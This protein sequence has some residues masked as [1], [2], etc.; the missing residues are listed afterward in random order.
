MRERVPV[1][2][3]P[4][5]YEAGNAVFMDIPDSSGERQYQQTSV[6]EA[7]ELADLC[8]RRADMQHLELFEEAVKQV[9]ARPCRN[10]CT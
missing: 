10:V 8:R 5:M 3:P 4:Q 2:L 9:R 7:R 6:A 1:Q